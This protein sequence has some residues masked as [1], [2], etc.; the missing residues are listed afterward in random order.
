MDKNKD[1]Q[2]GNQEK[3]DVFSAPE[4]KIKQEFK[5]SFQNWFKKNVKIIIPVSII[6][7]LLIILFIFI[8]SNKSKLFPPEMNSNYIKNYHTGLESNIEFILLNLHN[9]LPVPDSIEFY[10]D[11]V[12]YIRKDVTEMLS[13][14]KL[15]KVLSEMGFVYSIVI[16][17][18]SFKDLD[19]ES[20]IYRANYND[21]EKNLVY[22]E[23]V[24][25]FI[26]RDNI[27]TIKSLE[28]NYEYFKSVEIPATEIPKD[29]TKKPVKKDSVITVD[30]TIKIK[31]DTTSNVNDK[32]ETIK[33]DDKKTEENEKE[34]NEK[35][36]DVKTEET[37]KDKP[38]RR[39]STKK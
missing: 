18:K 33:E 26:N 36:Q 21:N 17:F 8:N 12:K 29:T 14:D 13:R 9:N 35:K 28:L 7:L 20:W 37:D 4:I 38:A 39:D 10:A 22:A 15:G 5:K 34:K 31:K 30:S 24:L 23:F 19:V 32:E 1:N 3:R 16:D 2:P 27:I 11:S 6:I 25:D